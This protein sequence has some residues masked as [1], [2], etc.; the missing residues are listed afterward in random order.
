[1]FSLNSMIYGYSKLYGAQSA[2]NLF[3]QMHKRDVVSWNMI[4][5]ILSKHGNIMKKLG[6]FIRMCYQGFKTNSIT[7]ANVLCASTSVDF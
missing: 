5:S 3:D 1:M 2:L 6:M 7:Y 4:I